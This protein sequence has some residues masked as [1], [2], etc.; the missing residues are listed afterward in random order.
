MSYRITLPSENSDSLCSLPNGSELYLKIRLRSFLKLWT[1]QL[2][3][4]DKN[5]IT[6]ERPLI[7]NLNLFKQYSYLRRKYGIFYVEESNPG[8]FTLENSLNNSIHL[9]WKE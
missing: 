1:I 6:D 7:F 9:F 5:D 2:A 8:I 4:L 3:D